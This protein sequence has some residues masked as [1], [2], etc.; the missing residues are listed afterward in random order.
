MIPRFGSPEAFDHTEMFPGNSAG[1]AFD[2][3]LLPTFLVTRTARSKHRSSPYPPPTQHTLVN[4]SRSKARSPTPADHVIPS[5]SPTPAPRAVISRPQTPALRVVVTG[6]PTPT[7]N[8]ITSRSATPA[9]GSATRNVRFADHSSTP[10]VRRG[11]RHRGDS[12][13]EDGSSVCSAPTVKVH[14]IRH[15]SIEAAPLRRIEGEDVGDSTDGSSD[16]EGKIPKP[17]GEVG[18]PKRGGYN[19]RDVLQWSNKDYEKVNVSMMGCF[20]LNN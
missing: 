6:P 18:R 15:T 2:H 14:V 4:S 9:P 8:V 10:S 13:S 1:V 12:D 7:S 19:L 20:D 17:E 3:T 11:L 16:G 5:R